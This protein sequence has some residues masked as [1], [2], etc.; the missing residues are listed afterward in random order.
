MITNDADNIM[1][2]GRGFNRLPH[3]FRSCILADH[4]KKNLSLPITTIKISVFFQ[5]GRHSGE[6]GHII[7]LSS[8]LPQQS[9]PSTGSIQSLLM[10]TT[11][12]TLDVDSISVP[13][14]S[15]PASWLIISRKTK[16]WGVG[17]GCHW[18]VAVL[19]SKWIFCPLF[20]ELGGISGSELLS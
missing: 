17:Y 6:N 19:Q 10:L 13:A 7:F 4:I 5:R 14:H 8:S 15:G 3:I 20:W 18:I 9:S 1:D 2:S 12:W 16:R 11:S